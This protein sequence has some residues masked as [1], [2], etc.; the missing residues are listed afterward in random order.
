MANR[1]TKANDFND[2][3]YDILASGNGNI[4]EELWNEYFSKSKRHGL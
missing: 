1:A 4:L 3:G 2:S